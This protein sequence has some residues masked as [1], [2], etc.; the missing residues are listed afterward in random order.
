MTLV[1]KDACWLILIC[2]AASAQISF[3]SGDLQLTFGDNST[4]FGLLS[5]QHHGENKY[6]FLAAKEP[7]QF[8]AAE[9]RDVQGLGYV[10][11]G[12][13]PS[14]RNYQ[15]NKLSGDQTKITFKWNSLVVSN[16]SVDVAV[17]VLL[18]NSRSFWNISISNIPENAGVTL[19]RVS[20][21]TLNNLRVTDKDDRTYVAS[22]LGSVASRPSHSAHY[23]SGSQSMQFTLFERQLNGKNPANNTVLYYGHHDPRGSQ[24]EHTLSTN[25]QGVSASWDVFPPDMGGTAQR[26][27]HLDYHAVLTT[28]SGSWWEGTQIYREWVINN[29]QWTKQGPLKTRKDV[30]TTIKDNAM[31]INTGWNSGVL[32]STVG[33]PDIVVKNVDTFLALFTKIKSVAMHWYVWHQVPFDTNYPDYFPPKSGFQQA[34]QYVESKGVHVV[35]YI[36][37]RLFDVNIPEWRKEHAIDHVTKQSSPRAAPTYFPEYLESY[38]SQQ[39]FAV[40]CPTTDYWQ[41]KISG[42][43]QKLV[44]N[45]GVTGVYIDQ[46]AAA[47]AKLCFDPDHDHSAGGGSYWNEGYHELYEQIRSKVPSKNFVITESN[48]EVFMAST[49]GYLVLAGYWDPN[50]VP[51]FN[52]IYNDY[53]I[54]LGQGFTQSDLIEQPDLFSTKFAMMFVYGSQLGWFA[55]DGFYGMLPLLTQP[56][57]RPYINFIELLVEYRTQQ[58]LQDYLVYGSLYGLVTVTD[59]LGTVGSLNLIQSAAW[60]P[61]TNTST[62]LVVVIANGSSEDAASVNIN[63][64][65]NFVPASTSCT[66]FRLSADGNLTKL[67][68]VLTPVIVYQTKVLPLDV[69]VVWITC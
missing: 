12:S 16:F 62:S 27:F 13:F 37:G 42:V 14:Q 61:Y 66:V 52:A 46:I 49:N 28:Y 20:F 56:Q 68:E 41:Q 26:E 54:T 45:Y 23:P 39:L 9:F 34:V 60:R 11:D 5:I 24:K 18:K 40:M 38:G 59:S 21:L 7:L 50:L 48:A 17:S 4:G 6:D 53:A 44:V 32:N 31:W 19:W 69:F 47:D 35:P 30:P 25:D 57:H 64:S 22:E 15:I 10:V 43:V 51:M 58:H 3:K 65:I 36:N 63:A 33:N 67:T 55:L 1:L 29:A 8:W 2:V